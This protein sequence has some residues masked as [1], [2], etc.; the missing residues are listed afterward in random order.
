MLNGTGVDGITTPAGGLQ[1]GVSYRVR[2]VLRG[3]QGEIWIDGVR[4]VSGHVTRNAAI[5]S[6]P[7][8]IAGSAGGDSVSPF[9]G[10]IDDLRIGC[11]RN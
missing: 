5:T 1:A 8:V 4:I 9:F 2:A 3:S 11:P 10:A 6:T 7:A